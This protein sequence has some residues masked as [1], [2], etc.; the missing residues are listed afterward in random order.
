MW[1]GQKA[2]REGRKV[3][4]RRTETL[5]VFVTIIAAIRT[6]MA[7]GWCDF[8]AALEF[9]EAP[10]VRCG[11][12]DKVVDPVPPQRMNFNNGFMRICRVRKRAIIIFTA[13]VGRIILT[14][15]ICWN[16]YSRHAFVKISYAAHIWLFVTDNARLVAIFI[17]AAS[18][19][20]ATR[21]NMTN[22][23]YRVIHSMD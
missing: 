15:R 3:N 14:W 19:F 23:T 18:S 13:R 2:S 6:A 12:R 16:F 20:E 5:D 7:Y 8:N 21:L 11:V 17:V 9:A 1:G 4:I 22:Q 10:Y